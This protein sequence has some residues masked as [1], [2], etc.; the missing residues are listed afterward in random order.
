MRTPTRTTMRPMLRSALLGLLAILAVAGSLAAQ[1]DRDWAYL[2]E[3][4]VDKA[5]DHDRIRAHRGPESFRAIRFQVKDGNIE[6]DR[7]KVRFHESYAAADRLMHVRIASG[8][9]SRAIDLPGG[10]RIIDS[11]EIWYRK[12]RSGERPTVL[13]YGLR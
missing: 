9:T 1:E 10:R 8:S 5:A 4:H 2:G 12:D 6:I 13:L 3:S 11:V 7:I